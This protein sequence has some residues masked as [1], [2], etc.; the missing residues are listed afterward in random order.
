MKLSAEIIGDLGRIMAEEIKAAERAA[1]AGVREAV[2]GL[3]NELRAQVTSAGLGARLARTWR[4]EIFPKGRNSIRAAGLVWSKAPGIIR[5]YED[6]A[7]I[8]SKNGFFLAIPTAAAGR[9][10]DGGRKITPGGWERR[11][12]QRLRFVYRRHAPS[13]LV[14][15]NMRARTGKRGGFARASAAALRSGRGLVTVPIFILAPQVTFRK[16]LDVA[17]AALRWQERLPGLVVR[18]WF[19]GDGG[20]R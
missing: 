1:T 9:Y 20:S 10:G 19:S 7:T 2:D 16:R 6:G 11:T 14:A 13:L 8:R 15:D 18:S 17:G 12:G 4:A 3:K 5:I